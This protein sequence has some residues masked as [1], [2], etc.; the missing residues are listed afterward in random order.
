MNFLNHI[1]V[2]HRFLLAGSMSV[3]LAAL[4]TYHFLRGELSNQAVARAEQVGVSPARDIFALSRLLQQHRGLSNRMLKGDA[5]ASA[6]LE[7]LQR[8]MEQ[9]QAGVTAY[10]DAA[11]KPET[12]KQW[13]RLQDEWTVLRGKIA[14]KSVSAPDSF[15]EHSALIWQVNRV[16]DMVLDDSGLALDP[17]AETYH[18]I[19]A[20]QEVSYLVEDQAKL[21]GLGAGLL[22]TQTASVEE[23]IQLKTLLAQS[24]EASERVNS[25][26]EKAASDSPEV[27]ARLQVSLTASAQASKKAFE[28]TNEHLLRGKDAGSGYSP[29]A[30]FKAMTEAVDSQFALADQGL[31]L[32]EEL[33]K[34]RHDENLQTLLLVLAAMVSAMVVGTAF[35]L[36]G[37][38]SVTSQLGGEP[39][40]VTRWVG[41]I[42][43]GDLTSSFQSRDAAEGSIVH[44]LTGMQVN[45]QRMVQQV[46][47]GAEQV[48]DA[49]GQIAAGN[50]DL[51]ERT[52]R[53][54]SAIEEISSSMEELLSTV[55]QNA[56]NARQAN[57]LASSASD[58]A[59]R[60]GVQM[61]EVVETM[62]A[63]NGSAQKIGDIIGVIDGIAFQTNI[64]ALNAAV[65]AAR[66]GEQGRGFAVVATEV[67]NL[68]QRSAVA[69]KE[70]KTLIADSIGKV[71][72]GSVLVGQTGDTMH[73]MVVSVRRVTDIMGEVSASS[74]EQT[75]GI[76]QV[77][78]A[79]MQMDQVTQQNAALVEEAAAAA[80]ALRDQ[81]THLRAQVSSFRVANSDRVS[82]FSIDSATLMA[83]PHR[84]PVTTLKP[85]P[86]PVKP[87]KPAPVRK[88]LPTPAPEEL[89]RPAQ[90]SPP[91]AS[92]S[93]P[94]P[95]ASKPAAAMHS[96]DDWEEF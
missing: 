39:G 48:V 15:A 94:P 17:V 6:G 45:L 82:P 30:Y 64:L 54:A 20:S 95:P 74:V 57:G 42:A 4:P 55:R 10:V 8:A 72:Q 33:L 96:E 52:E 34:K 23:M 44:A 47:G 89:R 65:E 27:Q 18:L 12:R 88:S 50:T 92:A 86:V 13:K 81:S 59:S 75:S 5:Q 56:D 21:R 35:S 61:A 53:Q 51:S 24:Q 22:T 68:A 62:R 43:Q 46:R 25:L 26:F 60:G 78:A 14:S 77:N 87:M 31:A 91:S 16:L 11:G 9:K 76:E 85:A 70:I 28:L 63:I 66:A 1:K 32:V 38:R 2:S 69:A 19:I 49:A 7:P 90:S 84:E 83:P 36:L 73:E 79:I 41:T 80:D 71:E 58:V 3:V 29:D 93:V 67:R 37:G 40:D